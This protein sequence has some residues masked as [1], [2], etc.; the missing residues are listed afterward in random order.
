MDPHGI[1]TEELRA[2]VAELIG[3]EPEA[4]SLDANLF[5]LGLESIVLMRLVGRFRKQGRAVTFADLAAR[6]TVSAWSELVGAAIE[7]APGLTARTSESSRLDTGSFDLAVLQHSYWIGRSAEQRFGGVAPHLYTEFDGEGVDPDRLRDALDGVARRH[8]MLRARITD[9]GQQVI[10]STP[11]WRGLTV[12]DLRRA[13]DAA[14]ELERTRQRLTHHMLDIEAGEVFSADLSLLP[15]GRTRLHLDMDMIAGDAVSFRILVADLAQAYDGRSL[16]AI[17]YSYERYLTDRPED[18]R[19]ARAQAERYWS[20]RLDSLPGAPTLP[21]LERDSG[22]PVATRWAFHL[23]S[24]AYSHLQSQARAHGVTPAVTVAAAF[25]EVVGAWSREQRF[26]LNVPMFDR[27]PTH[28]A[29]GQLVGDFSSS[30]MLDVDLSENLSFAERSR[31]LRARLHEDA[32]HVDYSGVEVLRDLG[33]RRGEPVLAPV[34]F[35][36]ALGLGELFDGRAREVFGDPVWIM[37]Q[38]P[39]VVLDA[40]ITE[41][42][43]GVLVNWDIRENEFLPGV[44]EAMFDAFETLVRSIVVDDAVWRKPVGQLAP[45]RQLLSRTPAADVPRTDASPTVGTRTLHRAFFDRAAGTPDAI[46]LEWGDD[47][48]MTYSELC[49]RALRVAAALTDRGVAVGDTV[50]VTLPKGPDQ[51]TAVLGVL[52]AGGVYVP[53]G[54]DQPASR[55]AL[56]AGKAGFAVTI[57]GSGDDGLAVADAVLGEA[58]PAPHL[59]PDTA[60]AYMIF[61]SG[62]TGEPKG[63]V[64]SHRAAMNTI[65][66]L[67]GR[68][69]LDEGY[70]PLCL[71][72]L[73]FDLCTFDLFSVFA[74]GGTAV[75]IEE[76]ERKDPQRWAALIRAHRVTVISCVPPLLDMILSTGEDLGGSLEVVMLGGDKVGI[77]LYRRQTAAVPGCRFAGLG[78]A[79][80]TAIHNSICEVVDV[81]PNWRTVPFGVPLGCMA[82]RVVDARGHQVPDWVP[83]ELWVAGVGLADGY[84]GD[85]ER[86]NERFVDA[87]GYRWYRT[88]DLV[89]YG[90]GSMVEFLGRVDNQIKINGFRIELGEIESVLCDDAEVASAASVVDRAGAAVVMAA[91]VL[92]DRDADPDETVA[93]IIARAAERLPAHM[94]PERTVA[95]RALPLTVNGKIDSAAIVEQCRAAGNTERVQARV[96]P[97]THLERALASIWQTVLGVDEIG[98]TDTLFALGGDSVLATTIVARTRAAFDITYVTVRMLFAAPTVSGL[99]ESMIVAAGDT[100]LLEA[101]AEIYVS[102]ESMSE[103]QLLAALDQQ[104]TP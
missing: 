94:V 92:A 68:F 75:L 35:T 34:V 39:Q 54:V 60:P 90:T 62:S 87:D 5:E 61:T 40:Q 26:I 48:S 81:D 78:G 33:R 25:A 96:A 88:G 13:D 56:I 85:P 98:V 2:Q 23:D 19:N 43:G 14:A 31:Q 70:R 84:L 24:Q 103:D 91:V 7:P 32:S 57:G 47:E 45:S 65:S 89:R 55:A 37:S 18:R 4:V 58:L 97:R 44:P 95:L 59:G 8:D 9:N 46:A 53:I 49:D 27:A 6:P 74:A 17:D 82:L 51:V 36:S 42:D 71:S 29:V 64:V 1:G 12:H 41:L 20:D 21:L 104:H 77:D 73:D 83:G 16:P 52:A 3:T 63:V 99:A 80:E 76:H 50:G 15:D 11:G 28:P 72:E 100:E 30:V 102:I 66:D 22:S 101:T 67:I 93:G 79:T 10:E 86:T 38:G 69:E